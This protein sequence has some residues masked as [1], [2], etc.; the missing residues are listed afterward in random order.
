MQHRCLICILCIYL[1]VLKSI[2]L[3]Q[4]CRAGKL[5]LVRANNLHKVHCPLFCQALS[6][7]SSNCPSP[8]LRPQ[9][10]VFLWPYPSEKWIFQWTHIILIFSIFNPISVYFFMLEPHWKSHLVLS[11]EPPLKIEI[12]SSLPFWK[13][14]RRLNPSAEMGKFTIWSTYPML[15]KKNITSYEH[16]AFI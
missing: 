15:Y 16:L 10:I 7:K 11:Q 1:L 4:W 6:L 14:S 8:L 2:R 13:F 9:Y 5:S 12:L 3:V